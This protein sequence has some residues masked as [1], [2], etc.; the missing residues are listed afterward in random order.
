[1]DMVTGNDLLKSLVKSL[2]QVERWLAHGALEVLNNGP[3]EPEYVDTVKRMIVYPSEFDLFTAEDLFASLES[4]QSTA[5]LSG[6]LPITES[7][8]MVRAAIARLPGLPD[9]TQVAIRAEIE[10]LVNENAV[11]KALPAPESPPPAPTDQMPA[12][13]PGALAA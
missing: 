9:K 11:R 13:E 3:V 5:A 6:A 7:E 1:M 12:E 2:Q 8:L 10:G 4:L